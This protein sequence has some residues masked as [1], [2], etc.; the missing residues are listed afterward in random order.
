MRIKK[1]IIN[2]FKSF[3][4]TDTIIEI[5]KLSVFI[6]ANSSGK[7]ATMQALL[8]IFS[9][10]N[11]DRFIERSD[12]HVPTG[13][14]PLN[15]LD[16]SLSIEAIIE[17]NE[18]D[19]DYHGSSVSIPPH[20]NH[21][22]AD[23]TDGSPYVRIRLEASLSEGNTPEGDI[24]QDLNYILSPVGTPRENENKQRVKASERSQIQMIYIP[25]IRDPAKQL[26]S[27]S[28]TILGRILKGI[29]WPKEMNEL[30]QDE[31]TKVDE[32]FDEVEGVKQLR[33]VLNTQWGK[34]HTDFRYGSTS[35][36]FNHADLDSI[37]SKVEVYFKPTE[38]GNKYTVNQLGDGL[39]SIFY[40]T[41]VNSLLD[42]ENKAL[43][44]DADD[45]NK[46]YNLLPPA[47]TLL[48]VEE[49]ENHISP[50]LL[51]RIMKGLKEVAN[52]E[53]SQV[54]VSTHSPSMI[55]RVEPESILH[56]RIDQSEINTMIE[57]INLPDKSLEEEYKF[58]KGAVM[59]Y[60]E[61]YF[62]E[63]V[64]LGEGDSEEI[65]IPKI[66]EL[67]DTTL[68]ESNIS[69]VPLGGRHV[70]H[71][72]K[73]LNQLKIPHVTL[74]DLDIERSGGGW[75]RIKYALQ[76]L[77]ING[78]PK[79]DLLEIED[80]ILSDENLSEMHTWVLEKDKGIIDDWINKLNNYGVYFS[81]PLDIDFMMI[82]NF[83]EF[84]KKTIPTNGG[85]QGIENGKGSPEY[86]KI[87][88]KGIRATLKDEGGNG[89]TYEDHQKDLMIWYNYFFLGRGKTTTHI[90]ALENIDSETLK[91][92]LPNSFNKLL[93]RINL[94]L[95]GGY[96]E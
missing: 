16:S 48:A 96:Y 70:N 82:E 78:Y 18:L 57:K 41:L 42:I 59:A 69:V 17:F 22:V 10:H 83:L 39:R 80:G 32:I 12:F 89:D 61:I 44:D 56:F 93:E 24:E 75:G 50:H 7:T 65:I 81:Y 1:I 23:E 77:I 88:K 74:L 71:F 95:K 90:M 60:P 76:Q 8:K 63:L 52:N 92:N 30:I 72:W 68:D 33:N 13:S 53:N 15:Y 40:L 25:A 4:P 67:L 34:Y 6:G 73:L 49:P 29:N 43:H 36:A 28:G 35:V 62:S 91:E 37:L 51:G 2:N 47:L 86:Q 21:M 58:I 66:I 27:A 64:V 46:T 94:K 31:I 11:R 38:T 54:L 79:E 84:Y 26:K 55:K 85:P 3:G 45:D 14:N 19:K 87:Y 20:F 5:N 9:P